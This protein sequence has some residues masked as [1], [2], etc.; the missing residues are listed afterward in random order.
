MAS[1]LERA[2]KAYELFGD[3]IWQNVTL[4][5]TT[6]ASGLD[7]S[8]SELNALFEIRDVPNLT[9]SEVAERT[10]LSLA[11]ASQLIERMVKRGLV[12]RQ[13]DPSN[14]RQKRIKLNR[15]GEKLLES[16]GVMYNQATRD[17]LA[18]LPNEVL[19]RFEKLFYDIN[20]VL[21][22]KN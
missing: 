8:L 14:R 20:T 10:K 16:L 7:L 19:A 21:E 12:L 2:T 6:E 17:L 9:V 4:D 22:K 15:D 5:L 3:R 11:A 1:R 18:Q 13:E